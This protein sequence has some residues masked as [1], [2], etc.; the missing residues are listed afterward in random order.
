MRETL[1]RI[2]LEFTEAADQPFKDHPLA[3]FI[4]NDSCDQIR[5]LLS[6]RYRRLIIKGSPGQSHWATV[7]W[8]A[9]FDPAVTEFA[10]RGYYVVYLFSAD[11]RRIY[12]SLN[13]GTTAVREEFGPQAIEELERRSALIC[14][15][16]PEFNGRFDNSPIDLASNLTLPRGYEAAH[17]FGIKYSASDIPQ[18]DQLSSD[19]TELVR[20][21]MLLR[22]RGGV[23]QLDE[24]T[25]DEDGGQQGTITERRKYRFHRSIERNQAASRKA[26]KVHGYVCQGCSFDFEVVYGEVGHQYIEAHHLTP[27]SELPDDQPVELDPKEDFA[28]LC[29]NCHRMF[30]RKDGPRTIEEL[31]ILLK[32]HQG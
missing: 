13:Q 19:L 8:I 6:E 11:M 17:A 26:K 18:T 24:N 9:V 7:P 15:R 16:V 25:Q 23:L 20:L 29:G 2:A 21:Y 1:Q 28:V 5:E 14:S 31:K 3:N 27:L 22:S 10:I 30:H 4:R 12:L 32:R